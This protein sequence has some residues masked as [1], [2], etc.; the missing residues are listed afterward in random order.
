MGVE[1]AVPKVIEDRSVKLVC[2]AASDDGD[3]STRQAAILGRKGGRLDLE[4]LQR[5]HGNQ[6]IESA[7]RAGLERRTAGAGTGRTMRG[8]SHV[9]TA[10]VPG[11][12]ICGR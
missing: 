8:D 10:A 7:A 1:G 2:A 5:I 9:R 11:E 4:L 6:V 3:L 12:V